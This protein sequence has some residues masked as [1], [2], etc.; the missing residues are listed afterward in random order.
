MRGWMSLE[1]VVHDVRYAARTLRKS[2]GFTAVAVAML[3]LGIGANTAIFSLVSAVLLRP[4]PFPNPDRLVLIW[5]D[6]SARRGPARVEPTP[7]DYVRWK[8]SSRSFADMAAFI[9]NTYNLTG[10]GE[11]EKLAGVRTTANLFSL[12][13]LQPLIGRTLTPDDERS[14]AAPVVVLDE[15]FWRSRFGADPSIVGRTI[16]LNGLAHTVVGIVPSDFLFPN[17]NVSAWVP[18]RFSAVELG[19]RG[20]Y[21]FYVLGRLKPGTSLRDAQTEMS[22]VARRLASEYPRSNT[23]VGVTVSELHEHLT[24]TARPTMSILLGAVGLV[25]LIACANLANLLLARGASRQKE[26][27]VRQALGASR[28]TLTRQLLIESALLAAAGATLG[29]LLATSAF[30]YLTRL[31]PNALPHSSMPS[32]DV[33]VLAFTVAVSAVMVLLFGA[34]PASV[35]A[36]IGLDA[37]LKAGASR[38]T[39]ASGG[40]RLRSALVMTEITITVVLLIAAG[41]LLRSYAKVLA[42]DPGFR[43]DQLLIAET[44]LPPSAYSAPERRAAFYRGVL[45]RVRA[46]PSVSSAAYVNFPPL[47]FKGGK[48]L[49]SIE[50]RPAPAREDT[51]RY[52]VNDRVVGTDYFTTLG[53]PVLRGRQFSER[54]GADSPLAVVI[55]QKLAS[56]HWPSEDPVGRRIKVGPPDSPLP[57]LTIVGVVGDM[58]QMGLDTPPE[59]ELYL[60]SEQRMFAA[61]PFFWPQHLVV[62]TT[63]EPLAIANDVRQIV[64]AVDPNEPVSSIKAMSEV[65]DAELLN[66]NTQLTLV[67]AFAILAVVM[68]SIGLYGVLAYGVAQTIPEIGVRLALGAGRTTV[69]VGIVRNALILAGTGVVLGAG[70]AFWLTRLISTWLFEVNPLDTVTFAA[71]ALLVGVIALFAVTVPAIRGASV[72]PW[73]VLRA[74]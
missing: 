2:P 68:A 41:L 74:D 23:D 65:F 7:G 29:V 59:S 61:A 22:V 47:V 50:G 55:N 37:A 19:E 1:A 45:D 30:T 39:T 66:R 9:P 25:L 20:A 18:A 16:A 71:T 38:G 54:D 15:P 24:R 36:R 51:V 3:A 72:D 12:L 62:R 35:A 42:V 63:G 17:K 69:V 11:P 49:I 13:G 27:A 48:V 58:R 53:V 31:V 67:A 28:G 5:D 10:S 56:V 70:A 60:S 32:L 6:L 44:V 43:P 57:W 64:R 40:R 52:V 8:T 73:A 34:G 4:L 33:R 26:L 46:L 14:D 21:Y